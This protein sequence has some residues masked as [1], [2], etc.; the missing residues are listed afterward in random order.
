[1]LERGKAQE[2]ETEGCAKPLKKIDTIFPTVAK[3]GCHINL[4]IDVFEAKV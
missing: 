1:M 2:C 4:H 3:V